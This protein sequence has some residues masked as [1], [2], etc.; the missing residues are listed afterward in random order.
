MKFLGYFSMISTLTISLS[1]IISIIPLMIYIF[2]TG[3]EEKGEGFGIF[4]YYL[5]KI[6]RIIKI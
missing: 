4:G 2:L 3:K 5:F 1:A 6:F